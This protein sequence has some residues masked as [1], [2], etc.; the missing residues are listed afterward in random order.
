ME[1]YRRLD[2]SEQAADQLKNRPRFVGNSAA[3]NVVSSHNH[4]NYYSNAD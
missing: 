1:R 4:Y 3:A 2:V